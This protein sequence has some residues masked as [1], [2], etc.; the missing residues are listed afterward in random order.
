MKRSLLLLAICL[1]AAAYAAGTPA[2]YGEPGCRI[3]QLEP[4]PAGDFVKWSGACKD[5][6]ANGP[7]VLEWRAAGQ[8][9]RKLEGTLSR[10]VVTGEGTLTSSNGS[11]IGTFRNGVPHGQGYFKYADGKGLYEGGVVDGERDGKGIFIDTDR[12]RYEGGW[13]GGKRDGQGRQTFTLGGSYEGEWKDDKFHGQGTI[14]YAGSGHRYEGRFE[15]GHV[16]GKAT[17]EVADNGQYALKRDQNKHGS[18]IREDMAVAFLP[19]ELPWG[20]LSAAEQN[21]FRSFYPA[22]EAGDEPP[23]PVDGQ[24]A[25]I[26]ALAKIRDAKFAEAT[27]PL[28]LYVLVGKDGKPKSVTSIGSPHPD[29]ARY[30]S[31]AAMAQAFKPAMCRGEPCEMIYPLSLDFTL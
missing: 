30:A 12:S 10:G 2:W 29:L 3:A 14:V 22:L 9:E 26:E 8:G 4:A 6:Y 23:F 31:M 17:E 7:G 19:P 27:G 15:H 16:A 21:L 11:Y 24:R 5:G 13:K 1:P 28:L 18:R 20:K 25:L